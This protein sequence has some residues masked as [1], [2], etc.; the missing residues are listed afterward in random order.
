M[1]V[2]ETDLP[3]IGKKFVIDTRG[4]DKLVI[5]IHD[6][7][8]RE[9]YHY[10]YDDPEESISMISVDDD[11]ARQIAAI[12]GGL[13]YKPKALETIDMALDELIIEWYRIEPHYYGVGKSIGDLGVRQ[14]S[15]ATIIAVVNKN[16]KQIN[17]GPDVI[18]TADSTLVVVGER[19]Q[20]RLFK[21]ILIDGR[22]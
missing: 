4:G 2:R 12:V 6:D 5:I 13:T 8:R 9:M 19:Q 21:Q 20:Q 18:I 15:G 17:P 1:H 14:S 3:G 10:E 7:G 22:G 16:S 11:E